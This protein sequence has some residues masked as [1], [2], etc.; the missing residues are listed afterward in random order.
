MGF[1]EDD[2]GDEEELV[3]LDGFRMNRDGDGR[4]QKYEMATVVAVLA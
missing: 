2:E 3:R 1:G 4:R